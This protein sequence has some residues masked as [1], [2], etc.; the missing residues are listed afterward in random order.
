[1]REFKKEKN[2]KVN[3]FFLV[4]LLFATNKSSIL[5]QA[6]NLQK[7]SKYKKAYELYKKIPNDIHAINN[8]A[9]LIYLQKIPENQ[10]KAVELLENA[11]KKGI[12]N[13]HLYFN[14]A[15]MYFYGYVDN[16]T[17][18]V[19]I[20]RKEAI[21]LLKKAIKLGSKKAEMFYKSIYSSTKNKDINNTNKK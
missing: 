6:I 11:I 4:S 17:K 7:E 13:K 16:N 1:M 19:Y 9:M 18:K 5:K 12:K 15:V 14:L 2:E 20:K 3:L 10:G 21:E 8:M